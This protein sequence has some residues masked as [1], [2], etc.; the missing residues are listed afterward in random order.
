MSIAIFNTER[1]GDSIMAFPAIERVANAFKSEGVILVN[2][3]DSA[4]LYKETRLFDEVIEYPY[5]GARMRDVRRLITTLRAKNIRMI[6]IV[7]GGFFAAYIARRAGIPRRIGHKKDGRSLLLTDALPMNNVRRHQTRVVADLLAPLGLTLETETPRIPLYKNTKTPHMPWRKKGQTVIGIAPFTR[8]DTGK[9]YPIEKWKTLI[10]RLDRRKNTTLVIF[11]SQDESVR[12]R[13]RLDD[14][15]FQFGS[16]VDCVGAFNLLH[17]AHALRECDVCVANDSG[18]MH[19][20]YAVGTPTVVLIGAT[21]PENTAPLAAHTRI[22]QGTYAPKASS[23][24]E[25]KKAIASIEEERIIA[26]IDELL[27]EGRP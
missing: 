13:N 9:M 20:S 2:S 10:A 11:G 22:V 12:Y 1:I 6:F 3:P 15:T 16:V 18:L 7:P 26:A 14:L 27:K 24:E 21:I 5:R 17:S 25:R 23:N 19:L 8:D 4:L